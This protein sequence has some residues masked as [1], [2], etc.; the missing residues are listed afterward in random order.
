MPGSGGK[1]YDREHFAR[2]WNDG[3]RT[4]IIAER[5]G[6]VSAAAVGDYAAKL[7]QLYGV[8]LE[9]RKRRGRPAGSKQK[10]PTDKPDW[11]LVRAALPP[12]VVYDAAGRPVALMDTLTRA[13]HPL[14]AGESVDAARE[15]LRLVLAP[16]PAPEYYRRGEGDEH[17][18][19][20]S[21]AGIGGGVHHGEH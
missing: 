19:V 20:L 12:A 14:L 4:S 17:E 18:G 9:R 7:R 5:L 1:K 3:V 21:G 16:L 13:R 15:R 10:H 8:H 11:H 6:F 2:L